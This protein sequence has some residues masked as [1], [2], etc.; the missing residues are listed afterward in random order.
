MAINAL[1]ALSA[2]AQAASAGGQ[3]A[4]LGGGLAG[5]G[6]GAA[7]PVSD[8]G[9]LLESSVAGVEAQLGRAEGLSGQAAVGQAELVDVVTAIAAAETSLET[10]LAVRDEVIRAYQDIMKM[11]I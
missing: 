1:S 6:G 4:A 11:P 2:Y 5:L 3:S 10:M 9:A 8:F 7:A